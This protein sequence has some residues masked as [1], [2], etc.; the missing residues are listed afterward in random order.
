MYIKVT[1]VTR[2]YTYKDG[3]GTTVLSLTDETDYE[4]FLDKSDYLEIEPQLRRDQRRGYLSFKSYEHAPLSRDPTVNDDVSNGIEVG[5]R[6]FNTSTKKTFYC[7]DNT[8]GAA[9]WV[10]KTPPD[11]G[12]SPPGGSVT[13]FLGDL[14]YDSSA[15]LWYV[16]TSDPSGTSWAPTNPGMSG[17]GA[18]HL[19]TEGAGNPNGV[20]SGTR[21]NL[22]FDTEKDRWY[23]NNTHSGSGTSWHRMS[24]G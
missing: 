14:Y 1:S 5:D 4:G 2:T 21:G 3:S 7:E 20:I 6:W 10:S 11:S 12:T 24:A 19:I 13:G 22:Y 8:D 9:V 18:P 17:S 15:G 16:C 23:V